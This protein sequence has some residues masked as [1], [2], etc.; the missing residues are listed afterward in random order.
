MVNWCPKLQ[1]LVRHQFKK[2]IF[3]N[4]QHIQW[5]DSLFHISGSLYRHFR[6][7]FTLIWD[8]Y[9]MLCRQ[10]VSSRSTLPELLTGGGRPSARQGRGL[11]THLW[12][13]PAQH[14]LLYTW[15][16]CGRMYLPSWVSDGL[17]WHHNEERLLKAENVTEV[18]QKRLQENGAGSRVLVTTFTIK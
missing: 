8:F 9:L 2:H 3:L 17:S 15:A 10:V 14:H 6:L 13:L 11:W 7:T 4:L 16:L 5:W 1:T 12:I 18:R